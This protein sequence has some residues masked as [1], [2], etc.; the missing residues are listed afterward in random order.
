M[1][2]SIVIKIKNKEGHTDPFGFI[3]QEIV[4]IENEGQDT[5]VA[6]ILADEEYLIYNFSMKTKAIYSDLDEA[7]NSGEPRWMIEEVAACRKVPLK[8]NEQ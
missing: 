7:L 2:E 8:P 3:G 1:L 4:E 6:F 5:Y